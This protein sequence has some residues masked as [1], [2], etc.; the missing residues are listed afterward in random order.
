MKKFLSLLAALFMTLLL[1]TGC[2]SEE[3]RLATTYTDMFE[4]GKAYIS[5]TAE[6]ESE[7]MKIKQIQNIAMDGENMSME[8]IMDIPAFL[9]LPIETKII[10]KDKQL[11]I[12]DN[13]QQQ[14]ITFDISDK[15]DE[16][17]E[18]LASSD[19]GVFTTGTSDL[20]FIQSGNEEFKGEKLFFEEYKTP[21]G[22]CKYFFKDKALAGMSIKTDL[23]PEPLEATINEISEN[24]PE[25]IFEIPEE[26]TKVSAEE[27]GF[28]INLDQL[29]P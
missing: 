28:D 16:L 1:C 23:L 26:F 7:G 29:F 24:Y 5:S 3:K 6:Y 17:K 14:V 4:A 21:V 27:A 20:D 18:K 2:K 10:F 15:Y 9:P 11:Y 22:N 8:V 12:V 25:D 13:S 19:N